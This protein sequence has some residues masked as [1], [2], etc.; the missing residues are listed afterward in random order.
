MD[1]QGRSIRQISYP[2]SGILAIGDLPDGLYLLEARYLSGRKLLS[3][4]VIH[5]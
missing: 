2:K 4:F 3:K 1:L 5:R